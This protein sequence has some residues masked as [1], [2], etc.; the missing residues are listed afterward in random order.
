MLGSHQYPANEWTLLGK[1]EAS[2]AF[3]EQKFVLPQKVWAR[4]LKFRFLT[5]YEDEFYCTL[6]VIR[7]FGSTHIESIRQEIEESSKSM[8]RIKSVAGQASIKVNDTTNI[9]AEATN[10]VASQIA[11]TDNTTLPA[12]AKGTT[13]QNSGSPKEDDDDG[14][15]VAQDESRGNS[16]ND[17]VSK[18]VIQTELGT[19]GDNFT[20]VLRAAQKALEVDRWLCSLRVTR[21]STC[22]EN[23]TMISENLN[24]GDVSAPRAH[25][26]A[27]FANMSSFVRSTPA[28]E[29]GANKCGPVY[30]LKV[31]KASMC[32]DEYITA[33]VLAR[34]ITVCYRR[35]KPYEI[36]R[37]STMAFSHLV[38]RNTSAAGGGCF[39]CA[40]LGRYFCTQSVESEFGDNVNNVTKDTQPPEHTDLEEDG[41]VLLNG[42][43]SNVQEGADESDRN[44]KTIGPSSQSISGGSVE[45]IFKTLTSKVLQLELD[46]S[47][48]KQYVESV[49][50]T[51]TKL[52]RD[53]QDDLDKSAEE[54]RKLA[55]QVS[56]LQMQHSE[57]ARLR[58]AIAEEQN[59]RIRLEEELQQLRNVSLN[60]QQV[61]GDLAIIVCVAVCFSTLSLLSIF[62]KK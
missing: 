22:S 37:S 27:R 23:Y 54:R 29:S 12:P 14:N 45:S 44:L 33:A 32:P 30:E 4:Y 51:Y 60:A 19:E 61:M 39:F 3:G 53:I 9:E 18:Q 6:S 5:H 34:N 52:F 35:K 59:A 17:M 41:V 50:Q 8:E 46:Q 38:L 21:L 11:Q 49:V 13:H 31:L 15:D 2:P 40:P 47:L 43:L 10:L 48:L 55:A 7:V 26:C 57:L 42:G 16:T 25:L 56:E 58:E 1:F 36:E 28:G 62:R 20:F 24:V